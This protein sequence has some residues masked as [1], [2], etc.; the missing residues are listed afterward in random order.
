[1]MRALLID[2]AAKAS[3]KRVVDYAEAHPHILPTDGI[4]PGDDPHYVAHLSTYRCVFTFTRYVWRCLSISVPTDYP[5]P[6]AA[7]TIAELFGFTGWDGKSEIPPDGWH[8]FVD[9]S[10][11]FVALVQLR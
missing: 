10:K 3:V 11:H 4:V 2:D 8:F 9:K 1:M 6:I 7:Y 5:H